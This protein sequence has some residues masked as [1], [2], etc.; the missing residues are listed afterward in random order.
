[1]HHHL[2]TKLLGK[3]DSSSSPDYS[4]A[5]DVSKKK[6]KSVTNRDIF[7]CLA[8]GNEA[9]KY[10]N[11]CTVFDVH[12]LQMYEYDA[13]EVTCKLCNGCTNTGRVTFDAIR[14]AIEDVVLEIMNSEGFWAKNKFIGSKTLDLKLKTYMKTRLFPDQDSFVNENWN[15]LRSRSFQSKRSSW[16]SK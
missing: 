14:D 12:D 3:R 8:C 7:S 15:G 9:C 6:Q 2:A 13:C 4:P 16:L 1:M 11:G 10:E 5:G